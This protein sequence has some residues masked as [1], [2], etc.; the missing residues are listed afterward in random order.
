L[1]EPAGEEEYGRTDALGFQEVASEYGS[2]RALVASIIW[3]EAC[4]KLRK[5]LFISDEEAGA[6]LMTIGAWL[7]EADGD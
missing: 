1:F 4:D 2:V 3:Q 6:L 5:R 7:E